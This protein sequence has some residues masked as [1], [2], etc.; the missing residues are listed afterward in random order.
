MLTCPGRV[1]DMGV[2]IGLGLVRFESRVSVG[3]GW[4]LGRFGLWILG[5]GYGFW[6]D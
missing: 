1:S 4:A 6:Y 2:W 3:S 5:G